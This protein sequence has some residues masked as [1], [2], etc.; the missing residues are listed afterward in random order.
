MKTLCLLTGS[1]LRHTFFRQS[2]G[3]RPTFRIWRSY[4][5]GLEQSLDARLESTADSGNATEIEAQRAHA[6]ARA[7]SERDF[8]QLPV[9]LVKDLSQP[10]FI[11]K[12]AI[13][14]PEIVAEI[15]SSPTDL[16]CAYGCSLIK[17]DL[18]AKFAG[19]FLNLHL[20]LSPYYR[21]SGTNYFPLVNGEPE[22]V[23]ATFMFLDQ[24]ID[25]GKII[26]Q[27]RARVYP[28]DTVHSIGNRLIGDAVLV[29]AQLVERFAELQELP[30]QV[31]SQ[32]EK[33]YQR[34]HFT[35]DSLSQM[36]RNFAHGMI[37]R[38]L[39]QQQERE[40]KVPLIQQPA[41]AGVTR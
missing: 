23:G 16:I 26:H 24:G 40:R 17:S 15:V 3:T 25:T 1:E 18:V 37:E 31:P 34:K 20:G 27:I 30:Q 28:C 9:E 4:C 14:Q 41:L 32:S 5:E 22:Y 35:P 12:G 38:Y 2:M 10:R 7:Q 8:F 39:D 6:A 33:F 21:G 13:N 19:R 11:I 29:Y 36:Q